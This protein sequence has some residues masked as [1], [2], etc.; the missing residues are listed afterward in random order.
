MSVSLI[1]DSLR[2]SGNRARRLAANSSSC[3]SSQAGCDPSRLW[4]GH[5]TSLMQNILYDF[6]LALSSSSELIYTKPNHT[7]PNQI[8]TKRRNQAKLNQAEFSQIKLIKPKKQTKLNQSQPN[9]T[10]RYLKGFEMSKSSAQ[11][12][13]GP[14]LVD[15]LAD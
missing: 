4:V 13:Y 6:R 1:S 15:L 7:Q 5:S 10:L 9:Q 12:L 8:K 3:H 14:V 2:C 11:L